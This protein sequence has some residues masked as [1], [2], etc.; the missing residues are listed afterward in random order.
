MR[1]RNIKKEVK[2]TRKNPMKYSDCVRHAAHRA[3]WFSNGSHAERISVELQNT[4]AYAMCVCV[5][6]CASSVQILCTESSMLYCLAVLAI[7]VVRRR[8]EKK[9]LEFLLFGYVFF[10]SLLFL[11]FISVSNLSHT[12]TIIG[13]TLPVI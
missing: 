6:L 5:C 4:C 12:H 1:R 11:L 9:N 3:E 8:Q 10:L 2:R 7:Y 13:N